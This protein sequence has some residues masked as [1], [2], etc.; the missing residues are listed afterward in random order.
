MARMYC[1]E[2][3][4][5]NPIHRQKPVSAILFWEQLIKHVSKKAVTKAY[6]GLGHINDAPEIDV[7]TDE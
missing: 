4:K 5:M 2:H 3:S 6:F 7:M 1:W